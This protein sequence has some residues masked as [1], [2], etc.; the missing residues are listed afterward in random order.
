MTE[1]GAVTRVEKQKSELT[2]VISNQGIKQGLQLKAKGCNKY[3][4]YIVLLCDSN[5]R[6]QPL[7]LVFLILSCSLLGLVCTQI[8]WILRNHKGRLRTF[9]H[10]P[11]VF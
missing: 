4:C 2:S 9:R 1:P 8:P 7:L 5:F 11:R 10:R 3:K 6:P